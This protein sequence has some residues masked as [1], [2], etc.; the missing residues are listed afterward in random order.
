MKLTPGREADQCS[1]CDSLGSLKVYDS[2]TTGMAWSTN[3]TEPLITTKA[4]LVV[5][6]ASART[7]LM[8]TL[9]Q[10]T[11]QQMTDL[12][13]PHGWTVK[14]H[15]AHLSAW[16]HSVVYFLGG[17]PRSAELK[18]D[19]SLYREGSDDEINA[20]LYQRSKEIPLEVVLEEFHEVYQELMKMLQGLTNADLQK[21]YGEY[22]AEEGGDERI[23]IDVVY[24]NTT[25]HF[26]EHLD[27]IRGI[28]GR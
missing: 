16:E 1:L 4:K 28:V 9:D 18:I 3:M 23:A 26:K 20:V 19:L 25:G 13:D 12:H 22:V 27:S 17:R 10:L 11:N 15:I 7:A 24:S 21:T 2:P 6:I 5:S 8:E 14:D